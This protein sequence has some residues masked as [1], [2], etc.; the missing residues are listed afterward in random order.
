MSPEDN[1]GAETARKFREGLDCRNLLITESILLL[2]RYP[3]NYPDEA[4]DLS[5]LSSP[6]APKHPYLDVSS[7]R[8]QLLA[9]LEPTIEENLG[10]AM[11]FTIVMAL[12]ESAENLISER[13]QVARDAHAAVIAK[14]EEEENRRFTGTP[15]TRESFLAW[16]V[17]FG[18]EMEEVERLRAEEAAAEDKRKKSANSKDDIKLTGRQL[19]ERGLVG[20]GE[21]DIEEDGM[22]ALEGVDR[23]KIQA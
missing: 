6:D 21:E 13:A 16:R 7:D 8:D 11:I 10:I 18:T 3:A 22:D 5:I 4:P 14:A 1:G 17:K 19:W 12:K 20:K 2:V 15:V 23:L 9:A